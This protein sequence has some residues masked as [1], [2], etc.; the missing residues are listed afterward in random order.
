MSGMVLALLT[1][2]VQVT[3]LG[4]DVLGDAREVV[5]I[6]EVEPERLGAVALAEQHRRLLFGPGAVPGGDDDVV[7]LLG[8]RTGDG[9]AEAEAAACAGDECDLGPAARLMRPARPG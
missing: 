7:A 3:V 8:E 1:R 2:H 6:G 4:P 5:R 9:D